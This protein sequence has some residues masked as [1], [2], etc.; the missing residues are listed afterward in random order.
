MAQQVLAVQDADGRPLLGQGYDPVTHQFTVQESAPANTDAATGIPYAPEIVQLAAKNFPIAA[1]TGTTPITVK[2]APGY[3]K[4]IV[5][6]VTATVAMTFYDNASAASGTILYVTAA[7]VAAGT[8]IDIDMPFM[9]G[10]TVS[11]AS[12][13][14]GMILAYS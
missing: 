9:N 1:G 8:I 6:L 4:K 13:T 12:G 7:T 10:L 2:N 11:Q 5:V 14:A 3:L